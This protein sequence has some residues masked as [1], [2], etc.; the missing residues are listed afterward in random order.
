MDRVLFELTDRL[1]KRLVPA[2]IAELNSEDASLTEPA[3][4]MQAKLDKF[5]IRET[6]TKRIKESQLSK[7]KRNVHWLRTEYRRLKKLRNNF[8][9]QCNKLSASFANQ[10]KLESELNKYK[11][12]FERHL[13]GQV[14]YE[15]DQALVQSIQAAKETLRSHNAV[16]A[17][18]T[19]L[20]EGRAA[21]SAGIENSRKFHRFIVF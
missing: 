1:R 17:E 10:N 8:S 7:V 21:V 6:D 5:F 11:N 14:V 20:K 18:T 3:S 12:R 9:E 2:Y 15:T 16:E 13:N 4:L 19:K